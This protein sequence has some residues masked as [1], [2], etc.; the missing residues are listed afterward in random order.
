VFNTEFES[1]LVIDEKLLF[2]LSCL[3][4]E[5]ELVKHEI[6]KN[7]VIVDQIRSS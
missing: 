2:G 7:Y 5:I 4:F 3:I 6:N 1:N